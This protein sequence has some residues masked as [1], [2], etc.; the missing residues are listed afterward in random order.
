[1]KK[2][3]RGPLMRSPLFLTGLALAAV[4]LFI[5]LFGRFLAP[6]D[7]LA[8]DVANILAPPGAAYPLGTDDLG[9]CVLSRL[10]AGA[11]A[12]LGSALVVETVIFA[13]GLTVGTL[14][15]YFG[16]GRAGRAADAA[17]TGVIDILLA[18]PS[19]IL[20]LVVAGLMGRGLSNLMLAMC[21]VYW[22][23]HARVA[24]SLARSLRQRDF[25][26]ASVAAG[27][28]PLY[29]ITRRVLPHMLP[30]M[31]VFAALNMSQV[32]LGISAMSF[33]GLGAVPPAPEWGMMVSEARAYMHTN[34]AMLVGCIVCLLASVACFQCMAEGARDG[35]SVRKSQLGIPEAGYRR[36]LRRARRAAASKTNA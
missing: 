11:S 28:R 26:R 1:M 35:L 24:R 22:V 30:E 15:G 9:R 27:S 7:P 12:T 16:T 13:V 23:E 18:F 19:I 25:V 14:A 31:L 3:F 32:L 36:L 29:I 21:A 34:P 17:V 4:L 20:A 33:I 10:L 5:A 2:A 8:T 6:N